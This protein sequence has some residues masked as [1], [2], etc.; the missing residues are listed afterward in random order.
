MNE[1]LLQFIWQ[2]Q[3]FNHTS[4]ATTD[5]RSLHILHPGTLNKNA[6]PDFSA[7]K[8]KI[9]NTTW[10]GNIELHI[11]SSDWLLHKHT[12]D[13]NY[14]NIIL[15]VVWQHDKEIK[16]ANDNNIPTLELQSCVPKMMLQKF[17]RLMNTSDFIPCCFSLPALNEVGWLA[18]KE[19]LIVERLEKKSE[20]IITKLQQVNNNWEETFWQMLARGFGMKVNADAFEEMAKSLSVNI[21]AKHKNQIHQLEALL[22]GQAGLLQSNFEDSYAVMLQKEYQF[23]SKKYTLKTINKKPDFLRMRPNNFPTIRLAQ[24]AMLIHQSSHLFSKIKTAK[25]VNEIFKWFDVTAN[26]FWNYHYTLIDEQIFQPK[27]TG[28]TFIQHIIINT[29]VPVLFAYG[30][31]R[32]EHIWKDIAINFLTQLQAEQN[33]ITK[34]WKFYKVENKN[35][36]DSQALIHLKNNYCNYKR[37][38]DCAVGTKLLRE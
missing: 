36:F 20:L 31:V 24:L 33:V 37:C 38:L 34:Q 22:L 28:K 8:I 21:L 2:F 6:G 12:A 32:N 15:H 13:K 29:I 17:E 16:D 1:R 4:L 10:V 9:D 3:Y 30:L 26:D 19:R 7:A 18:W 11:K 5:E 35:A 14:S 23:L 27:Q 25:N